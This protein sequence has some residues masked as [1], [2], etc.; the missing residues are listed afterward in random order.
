MT[1]KSDPFQIDAGL[2]TDTGTVRR[3]NEDAILYVRPADSATI[4]HKGILAV[5]ADGMG[6]HQSGEV[7]SQLAVETISRQ[8]YQSSA[9][10]AQALEQ[11]VLEANQAVFTAAM[12]Q[13]HLQGM[14]TTVTALVLHDGQLWCAHVGDSRLYWITA[15]HIEQL[16]RDHSLVQELFEAGLLEAEEMASHP[17]KN[18]ITRSVGTHAAVDVDILGPRPVMDGDH[19]L[20]CS[21]GLYELVEDDEILAIVNSAPVRVACEKLVSLAKQRGAHDNVSVG[22]FACLANVH[23]PARLAITRTD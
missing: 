9:P 1:M 8:Y 17:E 18:I 20:L 15:G 19:F 22:I 16:T 4:Q 23:P 13:P 6:G 2:I 7:A 11:A 3:N 21:D 14:G 5:V 10:V 12:S